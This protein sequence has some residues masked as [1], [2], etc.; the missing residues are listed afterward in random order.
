MSEGQER[1]PRREIGDARV[2]RAMAHPVRLHI[3]ECL[4]QLGR[5]T[6]TELAAR[7][8]Q[9]VANTSWHLRQLARYG[10]VEEADGGSGRQRPWR[11][12]VRS[13]APA[14]AS[15]D[16]P[17][18]SR[19]TDALTEVLLGRQ[20]EAFRAWQAVR[21]GAPQ[22]WRE[23]SFATFSWDYLTAEELAAFQQELRALFERHVLAHVDRID[24]ARRP[25]EVQ[26]VR[27][28]AW[29]FPADLPD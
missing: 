5:A 14:A 4:A 27:F 6:A 28:V 29:A 18:L 8:G 11:P 19:A 23:A 10:F 17:D 25:P 9:S 12:V 7:V 16:E 21:R 22:P 3:L 24:P 13:Y 15:G 2:L 26:P 1:L 20:V